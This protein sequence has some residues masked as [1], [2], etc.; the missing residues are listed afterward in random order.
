MFG[1]GGKRQGNRR[2][3]L[4]VI[5]AQLEGNPGRSRIMTNF[6]DLETPDPVINEPA[7]VKAGASA[8][9]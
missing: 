5:E 1:L 9:Y 8:S 6:H 4:S 3:F 2:L 7:P